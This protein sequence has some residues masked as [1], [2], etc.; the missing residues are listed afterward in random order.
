MIIETKIHKV[1]G[2][3]MIVIPPGMVDYYK[4]K[5]GKCKIEDVGENE[6]RLTFQKW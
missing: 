5:P 3:H 2:S 4:L 1:G 6:A